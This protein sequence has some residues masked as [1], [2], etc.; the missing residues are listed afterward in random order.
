[1]PV[2]I[3]DCDSD[4]GSEEHFKGLFERTGV[5]F[6]WLS[7]PMRP[8]GVAL[9]QLFTEAPSDRI[10]L[11]D[12]DL[13]ITSPS[14]VDEMRRALE[15]SGQAYGSGFIHPGSWM[16]P[17]EH[18]FPPGT[19]YYAER[20]WIPLVLLDTAIVRKSLAE[21]NSFRARKVFLELPEFPRLARVL[22][23]RYR[24]PLLSG[25]RLPRSPNSGCDLAVGALP[26]FIEFDTGAEVHASLKRMQYR[27]AALNA[28]RWRGVRHFHGITRSQKF[29]LDLVQ[30]LGLVSA[31]NDA[32]ADRSEIQVMERLAT[33][34]PEYRIAD[35]ANL[36]TLDGYR[37]E[38]E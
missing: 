13:E 35:S 15:G 38:G 30:K 28:D 2:L 34:F 8:H 5:D 12:S 20:M 25:L 27:F 10:L 36:T 6:F 16:L 32:R 21:G 31:H 26:A 24:V 17:P 37:A 19:A 4:D 3:V 7:W 9:D 29:G 22:G 18:K 23:Y 11:V 33:Q 1:M 14:L